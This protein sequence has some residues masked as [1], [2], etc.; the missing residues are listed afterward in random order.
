MQHITLTTGHVRESPRAEVAAATVP[1][2]RD[3]LRCALAGER[4][5]IPGVPQLCTL[6]A[7][8]TG[9]ALLATVCRSG[10]SSTSPRSVWHS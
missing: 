1:V 8:T 5:P 4:V 6:T 3:L 7:S 2:V 9:T 10:R